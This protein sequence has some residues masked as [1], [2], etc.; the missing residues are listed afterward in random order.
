MRYHITVHDSWG[1]L[2]E[3]MYSDTGIE[4]MAWQDLLVAEYPDSHVVRIEEEHT[5]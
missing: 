5:C 3:D 2:I 4:A 1:N